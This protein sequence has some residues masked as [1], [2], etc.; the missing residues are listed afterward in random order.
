MLSAVVTVVSNVSAGGST[1]LPAFRFVAADSTAVK[2]S[3]ARRDSAAIADSLAHVVHDSTYL[4]QLTLRRK[5]TPAAEAFPPVDNP[6]YLKSP[7]IVSQSVKLDS[8]GKFVLVR[9][10]VNGKD[11]RIP[12]K[13][14]LQEYIK[15]RASSDFAKNF[16]ELVNKEEAAKASKKKDDLGE[17][18]GTFT[19]IDIP[20]PANPVFSIF[21]PPRINLNISG[22]VDIRAAFRNTTTDQASYSPYGNSRN[23]PDFAQEVQINVNGTIG[24]KLNI[25]ADWNTQRTFEYEN[26]LK[27][28][29]TGY[30]DEIVQSVEA[31]NVALS[32]S[33][34][35]VSSSSALFGIKAAFQI[36]PLKLTAIASQKKG[37]IQEKNVS[38]GAANKEFEKRAYE[39]S[40]DHFFVDA[41]YKP[42][43]ER[44]M[45][46]K[47]APGN[48]EIKENEY[49]VWLSRTSSPVENTVYANAFF[50]LQSVPVNDTVTYKQ[51]RNKSYSTS[52][53]S[54][55]V[56]GN[57][58]KLE[59]GKDYLLNRATG[60]ITMNRTVTDGQA[61]AISYRFENGI[62]SDDDLI[63][64]MPW[65]SL[66]GDSVLVLKLVKPLNYSLPRDSALFGLMLKNIY[67]LG[68]SKIDR[69]GFELN[70]VYK[71]SGK[72]AEDVIGST[73]IVRLMGLDNVNAAGAATPDGEFDFNPGVTIDQARGE[74]IF[75]TLRPFTDGLRAALKE[76]EKTL[77]DSVIAKYLYD[78]LYDTTS[79]AA[80]Q[81]NLKDKFIIKGKVTASSSST[82]DLGFNVVEGSVVVSLNGQPLV[83]NVDYTVDYIIGQVLIKKQ[84]ALVPG[85]QLS[86]KFE[87]NDLFQLASK[88]L[89]GLRG[90]VDI[91]ERTKFGF[92]MMNLDQQVLSDKVRLN[93]EPTNNSIYGFDGQTSGD[94]PFLTK[95]IDALPLIDT[96]AKSEFTIRGEAA[97]M[98]PDPNTKK[99]TIAGDNGSGIAYIDDFEG[100]KRTIPFGVNY[101]AW[102]ESSPPAIAYSNG[103]AVPATDTQMIKSKARTYWYNNVNQV[104]VDDIY[105]FDAQGNRVKQVAR[106]QDRVQA[107]TVNYNPMK[108]GMYNFSM[109]L[110]TSLLDA[111][112]KNWGGIEKLLSV[113]SINL[114]SENVGFIEIWVN[115][116]KGRIDT[117]R[118]VYIDLG[119]I[120]EDVLVNRSW[121]TEDQGNF[122]NDQL[123]DKEDTGLDNKFNAEEQSYYKDFVAANRDAFPEVVDDPSGDD[124]A[125][126]TRDYLGTNG[127][128][129]NK[130]S[131]AGISPDTEDLNR[132]G[133]TDRANDYFTY[134][135]NLDTTAA[136]PQRIGG[137]YRGWYQY[138][139]PINSFKFKVGSPDQTNIQF[140]RL[141]FTGQKEE[142]EM[143]F[144]E[145]NLIGNQWEEVKK[146]DPVFKISV[147]NIEDNGLQGYIK[148]PGVERERDRTKP[149]EQVYGNE[150]SLA[151][152]MFGLTDGD[153][154]EA[155]KKFSYRALDVFKYREMKMFVHGDKAFSS[156][157]T[158]PSVNMYIRFGTDSLNYYEYRAPVVPDWD[159]RNN[160]RIN[161]EDITA[162]KQGRDSATGRVVGPVPGGPVGSTYAVRGNPSLRSVTFISIGVEN[163]IVNGSERRVTGQVWVNELRLSD[164][165]D[166][167]GWAYSVST[168]VKLADFGSMQFGFT[169]V[170]PYFHSLEAP[171]GSRVTSTSWNFSS[172]F[173][174]E[175]F[176]PPDWTGTK[177]PFSYS[178]TEAISTPQYVPSSDILVTKAAEQQRASTIAK[179]GST[180]AG[181]RQRD[182]ILAVAQSLSTTDTYSFP[183]FQITVLS[184]NWFFRDFFNRLTYGF[185]YTT[186]SSRNPTVASQTSWQ[187]STNLGYSYAF[188]PDNYVQPFG[189][190]ENLFLLEDFREFQFFYNPITNFATGF[191]LS[192]SRTNQR[193]RSQTKDNEPI[194]GLGASRRLTFSWKLTENGLLNLSGDYSL[195]I[196][197]TM[198]HMELDPWGRQRD[199]QQIL[200][201]ILMQDRLINFGYDNNYNQ[202]ISVN[203]RP[204]IPAALS[205]YITLS[206][207]YNVAYRWA[208]S[209][210]QG[211]LGIGV[212][213][214]NTISLASDISLKS[215]VETWFPA[216]PTG[217]ESEPVPAAPSRG[218]G[219]R[220][221]EEDTTPDQKK[222]DQPVVPPAPADTTAKG[223]KGE[224]II[225]IARILI[226]TPLLDYE[227]INIS[228]TQSNSAN[229]GGVPGRPGFANLFGRAPFVQRSE[230]AYGPSRA[231]QLGLVSTPGANITDVFFKSQFPFVG[232]NTDADKQI[233]ARGMRASDGFTQNNKLTFRTSRDL[234]EGARLDLNWNLG[235]NY[236]RTQT[237]QTD[238]LTGRASI[239][240]STAGGSIERSFMTLPPTFIFSMFKNG[241]GQVA[242]LYTASVPDDKTP[243]QEQKLAKAFEDG[244]ET[245]PVLKRI[246]GQYLPRVNYSLRWDG[247]EQYGIFK[248]FATKVSLDHAYQSSYSTVFKGNAD[249]VT[250]TESQRISYAFSPLVGLSIAFKELFKGT[251]SGNIRYGSNVSYDLT[252]ASKNIVEGVGNDLSVTGS[253]SKTGFEIP[254]FG[255]ALQNDID[256][257][258][259]Y[260][261][262]KNTRNTYDVK[263][264]TFNTKGTPGEGST[265][266]QMEPRV[267][268]VLSSRVTASLFYRYTKIAPDE[269][270]SKIPG[271]TTNE[272]GLDVHI[273]IQ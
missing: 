126:N 7:T 39:Y 216:K 42:Y 262:A 252:P 257:S 8:T 231:Y 178:H 14:P 98:N 152:N 113:S 170:D 17:L 108:R 11:I 58:D 221:D 238:S 131:P 256:I 230:F 192:R 130:K 117:T 223:P 61:V 3:S 253:F 27:I 163:P 93:E 94:L 183:G 119:S 153:S 203:T 250:T 267:R 41:A 269:G 141:W 13:I 20:V 202:S 204:R 186:S 122:K 236:S 148:P 80:Q 162:L 166:T 63:Y 110:K 244:F 102:H 176:L 85:A 43:Y 218:R 24:D 241:I 258:F 232:F 76:S 87:Q 214:S 237:I 54:G 265:R 145:F 127:L 159:A 158:K 74:I 83:A 264:K 175:K 66:A 99:S 246:F 77:Q 263:G 31:G 248:A 97:Y 247:L 96:K 92:T 109:D 52:S 198:V 179:T 9:Q 2:D 229:N 180:A 195:D 79:Q 271:S 133:N 160:V 116:S 118:K 226:K 73:K 59:P 111:P 181:D 60:V 251:M 194:R 86:V 33:S 209:L 212:G 272:G 124:Y 219:E 91:S 147:M 82:I 64:G 165:D 273:A 112:E 234:W 18:L 32:T 6:F 207:R 71:E 233:R 150:Q 227:K 254:L 185:S 107:L 23:E 215:F 196:S 134:E 208:N 205:K 140:A 89:L 29:Y 34:S 136:N 167:P 220:D 50:T 240:S 255:V 189:F 211:D 1:P 68:G 132:N 22:A 104:S 57:W 21:G 172:S 46:T 19:K 72:E 45:K 37:Q 171:F 177:L 125:Y 69:A 36:G 129:N 88:T 270:G 243:N 105:G 245:L 70:I 67:Y 206:A 174:F 44:Y 164:V 35:F 242:K 75:P 16:A 201:Q 106:G 30:E 95:A 51:F 217:N 103:L 260:S 149:D 28:K 184:D 157:P 182:S 10:T 25:L 224:G 188:S 151:L 84:E 139:I 135:L 38:G 259:T 193:L 199:F 49:E 228:F 128:E 101:G 173:A 144:V 143:N 53:D 55:I 249:G 268:Y 12:I 121:D 155:I 114:I 78:N 4:E 142:F 191:S 168:S 100:A 156:D 137:G 213:W 120:S 225:G 138:R 65:K 62:G 261:V 197:S 90:E 48:L 210:Q 47:E 115:V 161:F 266:T 56:A 26:Q 15:Q 222:P 154:R 146:N 200:N 235:W 123:E 5:E 81:N 40:K 169:R 190:F 239:L 187:W